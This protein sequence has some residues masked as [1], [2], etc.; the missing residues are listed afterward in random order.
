MSRF[1][2]QA[3]NSIKCNL[4]SI[5]YRATS[6][7]CIKPW[8]RQSIVNDKHFTMLSCACKMSRYG[9]RFLLGGIAWRHWLQLKLKRIYMSLILNYLMIAYQ[10]LYHALIYQIARIIVLS[11]VM[12]CIAFWYQDK[13][14]A[15]FLLSKVT[16]SS[17][18]TLMTHK[19]YAII[20]SDLLAS[21]DCHLAERY[22][23]IIIWIR[24]QRCACLVTWFALKWQQN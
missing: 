11:H 7:A 3:Q 24:S 23:I 10:W 15:I 12:S 9:L 19:L 2:D 4:I 17:D 1:K 16:I 5:G 13:W 22:Y 18:D 6:L 14:T 8:M 20:W 21:S